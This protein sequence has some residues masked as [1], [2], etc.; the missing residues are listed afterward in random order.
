MFSHRC[1]SG[2]RHAL[3]LLWCCGWTHCGS[4]I[5]PK[6]IINRIINPY[7]IIKKMTLNLPLYKSNMFEEKWNHVPFR[8]PAHKREIAL[9][10]IL[11]ITTFPSR[12]CGIATYSQDLVFA[13]KNQFSKSFSISICALKPKLK[14][15]LIFK[16]QSIS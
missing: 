7:F 12:E 6:K 11:F 10:E 3:Y 15:P 2:R 14:N 1:P 5:E 16:S 4:F 13:L 8:A 9:P